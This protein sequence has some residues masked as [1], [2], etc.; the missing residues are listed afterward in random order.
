MLLDRHGELLQQGTVLVD[1]RDHG[2]EPHVL[3]Y[4]EHAV[5]DG[6]TTATG[7][8]RVVSR[9]FDFVLLGP[10]E[11]VTVTGAAPYLDHRAATDVER[12]LLRPLLDEGWL[13]LGT[14][15][16]RARTIAV[17]H[18][19]P[20]HIEEV[21]SATSERVEKV[22]REVHARLT[23]EIHHW[24]HRAIELTE[25]LEAGRQPRMNPDR[26]S[27][28]AEELSVRLERRMRELDREADV[29]ALPPTISG[30]ALV[31]PAGLLQQLTGAPE[32]PPQHTREVERMERAAV[33]AVL[34]TERDLGH[35]PQEMPRNNPGFD[36]RSLTP[37]GHVRFLE[38]K[39]RIEGA[40]TVTIT[41]NE[42][43]T[44]LNSPRWI[45][46]LAE[47]ATDGATAVRYL[48]HPFRGQLDDLGFQETSRTF[49][50][51]PLWDAGAAPS[52]EGG[53]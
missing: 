9:R 22:R 12:E 3:T 8:P 25:Q 28:R 2:T 32:P 52:R 38:V 43:L 19:V 45:L 26:A 10:H 42:I 44:G 35:T 23:R 7:A 13:Q 39:G 27:R 16:E 5:A 18:V 40:E 48:H 50:W 21:R 37:D 46:A 31:V 34:A 14:L 1:E 36:I 6:R 24:D 4:I 17:T 11:E 15:A 30:A 51:G 29:R 20:R 47:V 49:A 33:D 41:R 53:R